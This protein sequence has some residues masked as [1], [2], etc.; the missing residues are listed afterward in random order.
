MRRIGRSR[1]FRERSGIAAATI[2]VEV[3]NERRFNRRY[4][5]RSLA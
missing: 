5:D 2:N 4:P 1:E 3:S